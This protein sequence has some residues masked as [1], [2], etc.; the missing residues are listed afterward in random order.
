MKEEIDDGM[1]D[2]PYPLMIIQ[3]DK[4][5]GLFNYRRP[6]GKPHP[7]DQMFVLLTSKF[8][9]ESLSMEDLKPSDKRTNI[10]CA[11]CGEYGD[12]ASANCD[13]LKGKIANAR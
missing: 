2:S 10:F 5:I 8:N 11:Y 7:V 4:S 12:H 3:P 13:K 9:G 1:E 6:K